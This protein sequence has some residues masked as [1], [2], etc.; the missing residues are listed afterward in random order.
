M[1]DRILELS[2]HPWARNLVSRAKLPIALPETLE[3]QEG[4]SVE[5]LLED[6]SV[7]VA[8]AGDMTEVLARTLARA[9]A[10]SWLATRQ[11]EQGFVDPGEAYGRHARL[12][13]DADADEHTVHAIVLDATRVSSPAELSLLFAT[14]RPWLGALAHHGRSLVLGRAPEHARNMHEA[15]AR[16]ALDGFNRS[17]AKE[18]G[19]RAATANLVY[20]DEGAEERAS[21]VLR[22]FLSKAS[23]FVTAQPL[24]VSAH[25]RWDGDDPLAQPLAGKVALVTGAARGI[26]EAIA[27]VLA[28][29]GAHVVCLDRPDDDAALSLVARDVGGSLLLCD[30]TAEDAPR[31]IAAQLAERHG[32][33]DIVVHNAAGRSGA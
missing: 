21:A 6:K 17:L 18:I 29:E 25:V 19:G 12:V 32:G 11:L 10:S 8:G 33:V 30:V 24:H 23:A 1:T 31:R 5:R 22:F 13:S 26:G 14:Y 9:G 3:R 28:V 20:V 16:A 15:A 27:R 7:L 2:Q 4:P